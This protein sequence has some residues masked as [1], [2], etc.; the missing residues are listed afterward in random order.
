MDE[1]FVPNQYARINRVKTK[2]IASQGSGVRT[3]RS[4]P[5]SVTLQ[6]RVAGEQT[7]KFAQSRLSLAQAKEL[8][9]FLVAL[10]KGD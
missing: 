9:E 6:I 8:G 10:S 3:Y 2:E 1:L 4:E 5:E 7:E